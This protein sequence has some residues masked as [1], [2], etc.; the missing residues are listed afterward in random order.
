[1]PADALN[2]EPT[3]SVGLISVKNYQKRLCEL[4][5]TSTWASP[6]HFPSQKINDSIQPRPRGLKQVAIQIEH[7][8]VGNILKH[9]NSDLSA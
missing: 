8:L 7:L 3:T 2:D 5:H 6:A 1:M 4:N 9:S